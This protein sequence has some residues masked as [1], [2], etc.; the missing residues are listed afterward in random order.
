MSSDEVN[1]LSDATARILGGVAPSSPFLLRIEGGSMLPLIPPGTAVKVEPLSAPPR[2][3]DVVVRIHGS[4]PIIHRVVGSRRS[5]RSEGFTVVTKGDNALRPDSPCDGRE[6]VGIVRWVLGVSA[7]GKLVPRR[8]PR[9]SGIWIARLSRL[10]GFLST[11]LADRIPK[12]KEG[13]PR[14]PV[15][16]LVLASRL[17]SRAF[18]AVIFLNAKAQGRKEFHMPRR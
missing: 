17:C 6:I 16:W 13:K 14:K 15:A 11:I 1:S 7:D 3:G 18:Y 12:G 4:T 10:V 9:L 5:R 2:V 8:L